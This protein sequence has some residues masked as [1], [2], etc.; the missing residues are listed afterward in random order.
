M[1]RPRRPPAAADRRERN[2]KRLE[3]ALPKF[4]Q[5][6]TELHPDAE[7]GG[8]ALVMLMAT[9]WIPGRMRDRDLHDMVEFVVESLRQPVEL[10]N[11]YLPGFQ[12]LWDSPV[13][14]SVNQWAVE[15]KRQRRTP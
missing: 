1:S 4:R 2:L 12:E 8:A 15:Q 14:Q 11:D 7:D 9:A 6:L 3:E 5:R 10:L 13:V